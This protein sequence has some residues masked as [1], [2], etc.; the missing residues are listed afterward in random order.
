MDEQ[1]QEA[2]GDWPEWVRDWVLPYLDDSILWPVLFALVAHVL[3]VIVPLMLQVWRYQNV[4]AGMMLLILLT[5]SVHLARMEW[6]A[7]GRP[8]GL[9]LVL[10]VVWLSSLPCVWLAETT[11]VL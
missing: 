10:T 9:T 8:R 1:E 11:G 3:I 6:Q 7:L 4:G 5:A 2:V